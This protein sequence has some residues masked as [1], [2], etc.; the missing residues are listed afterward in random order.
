MPDDWILY[1]ITPKDGSVP[2][3]RLHAKSPPQAWRLFRLLYCETAGPRRTYT[4]T[5][6]SPT[7]ETV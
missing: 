7:K 1:R 4:I 2:A 5:R 3:I 6:E